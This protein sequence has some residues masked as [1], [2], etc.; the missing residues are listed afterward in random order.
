M[1]TGLS[2]IYL[3]GDDSASFL[4]AEFQHIFLYRLYWRGGSWRPGQPYIVRPFLNHTE[5][6]RWKW[7]ICSQRE[8]E[9]ERERERG[10]GGW[11]REREREGEREGGEERENKI[12]SG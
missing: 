8:R 2:P 12:Q 3:S 7:C 5:L 6:L 11:E 1:T 9:G 10:G 4:I